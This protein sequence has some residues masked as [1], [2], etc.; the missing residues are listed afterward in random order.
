MAAQLSYFAKGKREIEMAHF[1]TIRAEQYVRLFYRLPLRV[2]A[3]EENKLITIE[4]NLKF[5][6]EDFNIQVAPNGWRRYQVGTVH[7]GLPSEWTPP[8]AFFMQDPR[9]QLSLSLKTLPNIAL[10][11]DRTNLEL[12]GIPERRAERLEDDLRFIGPQVQGYR[13]RE[14]DVKG[15]AVSFALASRQTIGPSKVAI[16]AHQHNDNTSLLPVLKSAMQ[17]LMMSLHSTEV[18]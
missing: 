5:N 4:E 12:F 13:L 1:I 10:L 3:S 11:D 7:L 17:N 14:P 2:F 9:G 16:L 6:S 8:T 18:H 15:E